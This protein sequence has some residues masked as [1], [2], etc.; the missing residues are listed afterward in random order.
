MRPYSHIP[1]FRIL[2]PFALGI[3][4]GIFMSF[5]V[6]PL[7]ALVAFSFLIILSYI[8]VKRIYRHYA[9]RFYFG[10]AA[11][12]FFFASGMLLTRLNTPYLDAYHYTHFPNPQHYLIRITEPYH[13]KQRSLKAEAT[14]EAVW[15][16]NRW[17]PCRG[18]TLVYFKTD[19][20]AKLLQYADLIVTSTK[21]QAINPPMNPGAFNYKRYLS[22]HQI[23]HQ[24][25]L[26]PE[27]WTYAGK[28]FSSCIFEYAYNLRKQFLNEIQNQI[29]AP[30]EVAVCSAL[31]IGFKDLLDAELISAY[32]SSGAL[33]VLCVSGLHVGLIFII[34]QYII[35]IPEN[36]PY[37]RIIKQVM[38]LSVIWFYAFLTGL[39]PSILRSATMISIIIM[40]KFLKRDNYMLNTTLLSAFLLLCF[41]PFMLTEVGFQL[42]YL[43][44]IGIVYLHQQLVKLFYPANRLLFH[45]WQLTS[46]SL[47]AQ[48]ITFPLGLLY[49]NQ[50]PNLFLVSNLLVIPL[51]TGIIWV[52]VGAMLLSMIPY[53]SVVVFYVWKIPFALTWIMNRA[54]LYAEQLP[55]SIVRGIYITV[56]ETWII[57]LII[58]LLIWFLLY[59]NRRA[60]FLAMTAIILLLVNFIN[61]EWKNI[62]QKRFAVYALKGQTA[63]EF[64]QS[65]K[66]IL[67]TTP[68]VM[69]NNSL[70]RFNLQRYWYE[71]G[72]QELKYIPLLN[73]KEDLT[74]VKTLT[75]TFQVSDFVAL[76]NDFIQFDDQLVFIPRHSLPVQQPS[77]KI[78][79]DFV[80]L[81]SAFTDKWTNLF[82][83][84]ETENVVVDASS[85]IKINN[86]LVPQGVTIYDCR[87][88]GAALTSFTD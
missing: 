86:E 69:N 49:F 59:K 72:M 5:P 73:V 19:S 6:N 88:N 57:Y 63:V 45:T 46:V 67:L 53:L 28:G 21:P 14:I 68:N 82:N 48:L 84:I 74:T 9:W 75:D 7:I 42:S 36:K 17:R 78:K 15:V 34:L 29:L 87:K 43:A 51:A 22:F 40:A 41:N 55:F 13:I 76:K 50:F 38:I 61:H 77:K 79:T 62:H 35:V 8:V 23:Y 37:L 80:V 3:V 25:Y 83:F 65:R 33:H 16:D 56:A 71:T 24:F 10:I 20:Q 70:I 47:C 27:S 2:L 64:A 1:I 30:R 85:R 31:L 44:V 52:A 26:T 81:T 4:A 12:M 66:G 39:S 32:A 60:L 18:K 58:A 11:F 54:L